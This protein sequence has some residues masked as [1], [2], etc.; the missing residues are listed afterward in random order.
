MRDAP[1]G[2]FDSGVG[3]LSV[4]RCAIDVMPEENYIYFGDSAHAPYG[5]RSKEEVLAL[6][7]QAADRLMQ[8][9][10]K[11]LD[12][13]CNTA[14]SIAV[15]ALRKALPIPVISMEPA[16]KPA[17]ERT[18]GK[19]LLMA[20]CV[21]LESER[22]NAL[23]RKLDT[24]SR[25]IKVPCPRLAEEIEKEVFGHSDL[26]EYLKEVLQDFRSCDASA[27]VLGCTHYSFISERIRRLLGEKVWIFDGIDGT[28]AHLRELLIQKGIKRDHKEKGSVSVQSSKKDDKTLALYHKL[29]S[30]GML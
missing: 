4:L 1:I 24:Q 21:T 29:L 15:E 3:G 25:I 7:L 18:E 11:A 19:I 2:F 14:T 17:L 10:I 22:V 30:G 12:V 16:I 23:I 9:K 5:V 8:Q 27:V 13:A 20:T 26:E 6:T 28:V